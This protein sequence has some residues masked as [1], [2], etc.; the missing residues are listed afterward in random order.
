MVFFSRWCACVVWDISID[1][2][3]GMKIM[4]MIKFFRLTPVPFRK[5][6]SNSSLCAFEGLPKKVFSAMLRACLDDDADLANLPD[7]EDLPEVLFS[8][9]NV[10]PQTS[11]LHLRCCWGIFCPGQC[12]KWGPCPFLGGVMV[13]N[14][15]DR[16][17]NWNANKQTSKQANKQTNK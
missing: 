8:A 14:K 11:S 3:V 1:E 17:P 6:I 10:S 9:M 15:E 2:F 13:A 16:Q 12:W 7:L 4:K 5:S